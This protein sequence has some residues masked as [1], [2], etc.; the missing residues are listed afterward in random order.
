MVRL[1]KVYN[2]II[3]RIYEKERDKKLDGS[4][5]GNISF[6]VEAEERL[7][8]TLVKECKGILRLGTG[9]GKLEGQSIQA[10]VRRFLEGNEVLAR[11]QAPEED[12]EQDPADTA[13]LEENQ[14]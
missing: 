3:K 2:N 5:K 11:G 7:W 10:Q 6:A 14:A 1:G 4:G 12:R 9:E 13:G 8:M